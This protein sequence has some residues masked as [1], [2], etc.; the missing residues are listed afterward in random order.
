MCDDIELAKKVELNMSAGVEL[1]SE[2]KERYTYAS[3]KRNKLLLNTAKDNSH[4]DGYVWGKLAGKEL[5]V[6]IQ[7]RAGIT[8]KKRDDLL[9]QLKKSKDTDEEVDLLFYARFVTAPTDIK[10]KN[11]LQIDFSLLS[12][13]GGLFCN[14]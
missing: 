10:R 13:C 14:K 1:S 8:E 2:K 5:P 9:K 4:H 12:V 11:V 6:P 7:I 3:S